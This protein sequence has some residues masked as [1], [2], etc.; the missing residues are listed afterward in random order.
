MYL[1]K[2]VIS[3][4]QLPV[5]DY[6]DMVPTC[7]EVQTALG[8]LKSRKAR[9]ESD[10]LSELLL[11][12]DSVIVDELTRLFEMAWKDECI[13]RDWCNALLVPVPK[14]GNLKLSD[15]WRGISLWMLWGR[16]R[17]EMFKI[18]LS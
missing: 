12:G 9:G 17:T 7:E 10:I 6:L 5:R 11:C 15:T 16:F 18:S 4:T 8:R 14:K 3:L 1:V 2:R 13:V